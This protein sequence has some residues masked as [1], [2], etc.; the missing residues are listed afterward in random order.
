M[1][2]RNPDTV[3]A[4][5]RWLNS[6]HGMTYR[7]ISEKPYFCTIPAGT[8]CAIANGYPIP[9]KHRPALGLQ[10]LVNVPADRVKKHPPQPPRKLTRCTFYRT[11]P[12]DKIIADLERVTGKRFMLCDDNTPDDGTIVARKV[13]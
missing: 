13:T 7:Q 5:I 9:N 6:C 4:W 12:V 2:V 8:I 11:T 3:L 10:P 1:P